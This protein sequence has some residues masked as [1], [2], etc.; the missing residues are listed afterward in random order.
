MYILGTKGCLFISCIAGETLLGA[1]PLG[2][3]SRFL[4][5]FRLS[6]SLNEEK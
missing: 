6:R 5:R 2:I 4:G 1:A 3:A